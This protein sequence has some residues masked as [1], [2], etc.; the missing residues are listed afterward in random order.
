MAPNNKKKQRIEGAATAS[1]AGSYANN[2]TAF[3]R[4]NFTQL[5]PKWS[6]SGRRHTPHRQLELGGPV[7][8]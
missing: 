3:F 6:E 1:F 5:K 7:G 4:G 8:Q 2:E